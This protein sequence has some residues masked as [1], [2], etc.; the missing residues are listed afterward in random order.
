MYHD[1]KRREQRI[2]PKKNSSF[3]I[4]KTII[5]EQAVIVLF[6]TILAAWYLV[7]N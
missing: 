6:V 2:A 5:A 4:I 3:K 7:T 1:I